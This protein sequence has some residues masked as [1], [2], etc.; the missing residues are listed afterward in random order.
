MKRYLGLIFAVLLIVIIVAS[1][2]LAY[3]YRA[4]LTIQEEN[5]NDY[6]MLANSVTSPNTWMAENG[7]MED[8]ALDTRVETLA[9]L[10]K[11]RMVS[12]DKILTAVPVP[13]NSQTNLYFTVGN[14]DDDMDIITGYDG[15][16][17]YPDDATV[18]DGD[19]FEHENS[20]YVDTDSGADK[21]LFYKENAIRTYISGDT[22][23][24]SEISYGPEFPVVEDVDGGNTAATTNHT[25]NLPAIVT[26]QMLIVLF[27]IDTNTVVTFPGGW[28]NLFDDV[29]GANNRFGAWYRIADGTEGATITVT[30]VGNEES[31]HTSFSISH[32]QGVPECGTSA[33]GASVNPDPPNLTPS[34]GAQETLWI[35]CAGIDR[36][37]AETITAYPA[38]YTDG[39]EDQYTA[40]GTTTSVGTARRE[41]N[42][43][44]ENPGTFTLDNISNWIAN[45]IAIAPASIIIEATGV[46]TG[47]IVVKTIGEYN[48]PIWATG[49]TLSFDGTANSRIDCGAIYDATATL[50]VSF[51][52]KLDNDFIDGVGLETHL[53]GKY[54]DGN[55]YL[56]IRLIPNARLE[57]RKY[58]A[59]VQ[60]FLM[61]ALP[62]EVG[63]PN[64]WA[65]NKWYHVIASVSL[66]N[67]ARMLI[68]GALRD[69]DP[70]NSAVCN[71]GNFLIGSSRPAPQAQR[72]DGQIQN[73][74]VGTDDLVPAEELAL[75]SGIAPGDETDYWFIDEGDGTDIFSYGSS[76]N[77]GTAEAATS[78]VTSTYTTDVTGR[79]CDYYLDIDSDRW[80][81]NLKGQTVPDNNNN[82]IIYEGN[83]S[84]Y[85]THYKHTVSSV[86]QVR[87]LPNDMIK[88]QAYSAGTVTVTNGD[89]TVVG[90]GTTWVDNMEG[91]LFVST[92][93]VQYVIDTIT[94]NT[95]LEL[96]TVY[97]GATLAGQAYNMYVRLPDRE[98]NIDGRITWGSNPAGVTVTLGSIVS[99]SQ[100]VPG[101]DITTPTI[102]ILPKGG[103]SD[104]FGD[105]T[106]G[107]PLLTFPLR[108]LVTLLSDNTTVTELQAWRLYALAITLLVTVCVGR[109]MRGHLLLAGIACACCIGAAWV[110]TIFPYWSLVFAI[111]VILG[112]IVAERS[113]NL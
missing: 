97:G 31:A 73:V 8:D 88:G 83:V 11:P 35:A 15:Y 9:G 32:Y 5:G 62:P 59:G 108:P 17:T 26:G 81:A 76:G 72:F 40:A 67:G 96:T 74:V 90:A 75:Y 54:V 28:D 106:V 57:V 111:A 19:D 46:T 51:W 85:A 112:G 53:W 60:S 94:D 48:A 82:W 103:G 110:L 25:V 38:N 29:N 63:P 101:A 56:Y 64:Y 52:F 69:T 7:F 44:S 13:A 6:D 34:W 41:L 99:A 47:K 39:R 23:I 66:A 30:S 80:G 21:N 42:A 93:G 109:V 50:W 113:I 3:T 20:A 107:A 1:P 98:S 24:T 92:D 78:W 68:N 22:D 104:W 58:D 27:S 70:D 71:G 10:Y 79:L 91:G 43:A 14:S 102:D 61:Y 33:T 37:G 77:D 36:A 95:H 45:T 12:S 100:P 4:S 105:H 55:N 49:N 65:A 18:E 87:Y 2:V 84:P 89:E 16:V 86:L